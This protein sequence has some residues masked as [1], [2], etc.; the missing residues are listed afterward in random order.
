MATWANTADGGSSGSNVTTGNSGGGSGNAFS[1]V[2]TDVYPG[3]GGTASIQF[4]GT[5]ARRG[6]L[7]YRCREFGGGSRVALTTGDL[8]SPTYQRLRFYLKVVQLPTEAVALIQPITA[9]GDNPGIIALDPDGVLAIHDYPDNIIGSMSNGLP[10]NTWLRIETIWDPSSSTSN[11]Q[12]RLAYAIG[13]GAPVETLTKTG[14]NLGTDTTVSRFQIGKAT[15][16]GL[17]SEFHIDDIAADNLGTNAT[18][19]GPTSLNKLQ[20]GST[21]VGL[22]VGTATPAAVYAGTTQLFP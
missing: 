6:T 21:S 19:I 8:G 5:A 2:A 15:Y 17:W 13:D 14:R 4:S 11:G 22:R 1:S 9:S 10:L 20:V 7:G 16:G 18:F 12:V 3:Y